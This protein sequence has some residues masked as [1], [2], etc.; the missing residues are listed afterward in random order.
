M[1]FAGGRMHMQKHTFQPKAPLEQKQL[2]L[3]QTLHQAFEQKVQRYPQA[4]VLNTENG[5]GLTYEQLNQRANQL[6][7]YI[8]QIKQQMGETDAFSP[9]IG[10][11]LEHDEEMLVSILAILKAGLAYL[12]I[13]STHGAER[14]GFY[15]EDAGIELVIGVLQYQSLFDESKVD[16]LCIDSE[17]AFIQ[18]MPLHNPDVSI[19]SDPLACIVYVS[20]TAGVSKGVEISHT[21]AMRLSAMR[22]L[23][24]E[25]YHL[26]LTKNNSTENDIWTLLDASTFEVHTMGK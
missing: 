17:K 18:T 13:N 25:K 14:I 3:T 4:I 15:I 22:S 21:S 24:A 9:V 12:P 11:C 23:R 8:L 1:K 16:Y 20:K 5:L 2:R 7:H 6:A 19:H 10:I 26:D